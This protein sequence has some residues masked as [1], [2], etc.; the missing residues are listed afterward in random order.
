M[1]TFPEIFAG[2][3]EHFAPW[4]IYS[5][6][7]WCS[8]IRDLFS[9]GGKIVLPEKGIYISAVMKRAY[10]NIYSIKERIDDMT[11]EEII[12]F[13]NIGSGEDFDVESIDRMSEWIALVK[14]NLR[15]SK[16]TLKEN[17]ALDQFRGWT[18][19]AVEQEIRDIYFEALKSKIEEIKKSTE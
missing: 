8:N 16:T 6:L 12:K 9:A 15:I 13:W 4:L 2:N 14:S 7:V 17:K 5:C 1:Y 10:D 19:E 18:D 3:Y 11:E